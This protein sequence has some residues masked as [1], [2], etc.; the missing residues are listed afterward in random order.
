MRLEAV[1]CDHQRVSDVVTSL[2]ET[3]M[4]ASSSYGFS[5]LMLLLHLAKPEILL[6]LVEIFR[7]Q[8][9]T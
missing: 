7:R 3:T 9:S 5:A 2:R 4:C 1:Q 8:S 6:V